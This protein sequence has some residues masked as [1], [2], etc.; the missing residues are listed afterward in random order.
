MKFIP[1]S[2]YSLDNYEFLEAAYRL[3]LER[4]PDTEGV[5]SYLAQMHQGLSK[6]EVILALY[7]S[8]ERRQKRFSPLRG[9][10]R[11][12]ARVL[13][14]KYAPSQYQL[15][16]PLRFT[17]PDT[18][19]MNVERN[20]LKQAPDLVFLQSL[21]PDRIG[22]SYTRMPLGD[23]YS[24]HAVFRSFSDIL[25]ALRLIDSDLDH[26]LPPQTE[27]QT[28]LQRATG[29]KLFSF[30]LW[31]TLVRRTCHPDA[32]KLSSARH[33]LIEYYNTLLPAFRSLPALM[34]A[35]LLAEKHE[36]HPHG[37]EYLF[38]KAA[39]IF[40]DSVVEYGTPIKKRALMRDSLM[41]YE[42]EVEKACSFP[43]P[44]CTALLNNIPHLHKVVTS[45]FY[46]DSRFLH[47]L[48]KHHNLEGAF[49]KIHASSEH[50]QSK[51]QGGLFDVVL[52]AFRLPASEVIHLGDHPH[53]DVDIPR[54][55]GIATVHYENT[56]FTPWQEAHGIVFSETAASERPAIDRMSLWKSYSLTSNLLSNK[57]EIKSDEIDCARLGRLLAPMAAG[58]ALFIIEQAKRSGAEKVFFFTREGIFLQKVYQLVTECDPYFSAYPATSVLEV[59]RVAT[60]AASLSTFDIPEFMRLWNMYSTQ[61]PA[62]FI[63]TLGVSP[64]EGR[65]LFRSSGLKYETPV[66][67]P[68][69]HAAFVKIIESRKFQKYIREYCVRRK[70]ELQGYLCSQGFPMSANSSVFTVD[71]GW[72]GTIQ[73]NIARTV[74]TFI[75]GTYLALF[76]FLNQ[77]PKNT[78]KAAYLFN[79]NSEVDRLEPADI[80]PME[81]LFN[82]PGGSV[83]GY[84]IAKD[85]RIIANKKV[86]SSEEEV[87]SASINAMQQGILEALPHVIA[88]VREN[89]LT[90]ETLKPTAINLMETLLIDPP[91]VFAEAYFHLNHN[92]VFG[93]GTSVDKSLEGNRPS[94]N[95]GNGQT[96]TVSATSAREA[97][98][99]RIGGSRWPQGLVAS[100]KKALNK[101]P[102]LEQLQLPPVAFD[103]LH[104]ATRPV[105]VVFF[106]PPAI[107]GSGGI[108]TMCNFARG[109]A[110]YGHEVFMYL[111]REGDGVSVIREML[112]EVRVHVHVGW[113][114]Y[115]PFDC[116][117]ATVAHSAPFVA[118]MPH[119]NHKFY[120]VQDFE[121]GFNPL[122]DGYVVGE[123]S[124][125]YGLTHLTIGRWLSH[126]I[127]SQYG[128]SAF[129]AGLGADTS[130]YRPLG[131]SVRKPAIAFLYQ[132]DKF[133]RAPELGIQAL[134]LVK[135]KHPETTI[136]L[137]GHDHKVHLDFPTEQL[138][139]ISNLDD[140]N[141]LYN[142]CTIGLCI[143]L[144]NPSRIPFEMMAAGCVP[145]DVYRYNNLFDYPDGTVLLAHQTPEA[146]AKAICWLIETPQALQKRSADCISFA[147]SRTLQW[148]VD[149]LTNTLHAIIKGLHLV[150][151]RTTPI[152]HSPPILTEVQ[153]NDSGCYRFCVSQA[154]QAGIEFSH[155][156]RVPV[157]SQRVMQN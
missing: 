107:R 148:E 96:D 57:R 87:H 73:D 6:E 42:L 27:H 41:K 15:A 153:H 72:R 40:V 90:S 144:S 109:L 105:K 11:L 120:F 95:E 23:I 83:T 9:M 33:L 142:K 18:T 45:D 58:Y 116:A 104:G 124:Y 25:E 113:V 82:S 3:L 102:L 44:W 13:F 138:G 35:R 121:A 86:E 34:R 49:L 147:S 74:P 106:I 112:G 4:D 19:T 108:R 156:D 64:E 28:I 20:N 31:D 47:E 129:P 70:K 24:S 53:S 97:L 43:D 69:K 115:L 135:D 16:L 85:G 78:T 150:G 134:S 143:S 1:D 122:S 60:F 75:H 136:Y 22:E 14:A 21:L 48:L 10:R 123:N 92:E 12:K 84:S 63:A 67:Y 117:I 36:G 101:L 141:L 119:V 51:R 59:S 98:S 114:N 76:R 17:A 139:L 29:R 68:W 7:G 93:T 146:L 26:S 88:H 89:A 32:V 5:I 110:N 80:T 37:G 152:Y 91:E 54:S 133:R 65:D 79:L 66:V 8:E 38:T 62:A 50:R 128:A 132:P 2:I 103:S 46:H 56:A 155:G 125:T 126:L 111:E 30:D 100:C 127:P 137:Y 52:D 149:T 118:E 130:V 131:R 145:V 140:I 154:Y 151:K 77:Q 71:I 55:K 39:G 81:M 94:S 61:S 157:I 99:M